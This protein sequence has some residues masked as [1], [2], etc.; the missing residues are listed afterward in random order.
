M[1]ILSIYSTPLL[2][3]DYDIFRNPLNLCLLIV[4]HVA[5]SFGW[6]SS[7]FV[8]AMTTLAVRLLI[9]WGYTTSDR[10]FS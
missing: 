5:L 7:D 8:D 1:Y 3:L 4:T 6:S 2:F 10:G 9:F